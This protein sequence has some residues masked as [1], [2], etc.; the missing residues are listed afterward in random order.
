MK[1]LEDLFEQYTHKQAVEDVELPSSG[2]NRRYFRLSSGTTT[3]IGAK[4]TSVEEN[5]AFM[6]LAK[7]FKKAGL[8]VPELYCASKDNVY[9]LQ[10]TLGM[11]P[12][13]MQFLKVATE[14]IMM[15]RRQS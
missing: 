1:Q 5:I 3:A 10:E 7:H 6:E 2:S 8:N 14:V 12:C 11:R 9:Y 15:A 13:L 4:G